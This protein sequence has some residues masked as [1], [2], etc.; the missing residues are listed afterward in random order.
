MRLMCHDARDGKVKNVVEPANRR[1]NGNGWESFFRFAVYPKH[2]WADTCAVMIAR[3]NHPSPRYRSPELMQCHT[4]IEGR[5]L[6]NVWSVG[7]SRKGNAHFAAY[8][9]A[10]VER[11]IAMSCPEYITENGPRERIV[12]PTVYDEG[13]RSNRAFGQYTLANAIDSQDE[14]HQSGD[15]FPNLPR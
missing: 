10:L 4:A 14:S 12:Q 8:P 13:R 5:N 6:T 7:T 15:Q 3:D 1:L 2:A 9:A 11:P